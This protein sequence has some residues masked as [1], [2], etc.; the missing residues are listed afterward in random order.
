LFKRTR[1]GATLF[2]ELL[3]LLGHRLRHLYS[4][5]L[6]VWQAV[7]NGVDFLDA[8]EQPTLDQLQKIH[9][10]AQAISVLTSSVEKEEFNR[11]DGLDLAKNVRFTL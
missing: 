3:P 10:N 11:V 9:H 1:A 2:F 6:K 7:C 4:L 5:H 8:N